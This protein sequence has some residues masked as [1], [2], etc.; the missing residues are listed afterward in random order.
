MGDAGR[1]LAEKEFA[2]PLLADRFIAT[3][4]AIPL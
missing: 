4:E 1:D 2:R 3:L